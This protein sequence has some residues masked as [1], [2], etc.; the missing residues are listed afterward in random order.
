MQRILMDALCLD[1]HSDLLL[2][3]GANIETVIEGM[4][5]LILLDF[6]GEGI[7]IE[8]IKVICTPA[9]TNQPLQHWLL[10]QATSSNPAHSLSLEML[11]A[12]L[13]EAICCAL[14]DHFHTVVIHAIDVHPTTQ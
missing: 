7:V 6:F 10:L 13:E 8:S 9:T 12:R 11:E 2:N 14:L 1:C 3:E 5:A 4:L